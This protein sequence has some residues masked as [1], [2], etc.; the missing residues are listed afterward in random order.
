MANYGKRDQRRA[1]V[2]AA[3]KAGEARPKPE[4]TVYRCSVCGAEASDTVRLQWHF[5]FNKVTVYCVP[6]LPD[7]L[8]G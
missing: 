1:E 2:V 8:R 6:H 3:F 4:P 7:D 5:G